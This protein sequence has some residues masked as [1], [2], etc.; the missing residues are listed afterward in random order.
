MRALTVEEI[1]MVDGGIKAALGGITEI[2][3]GL[4]LG[5]IGTALAGAAGVGYATGTWIYN[6]LPTSAQDTIGGTVAMAIENLG[7]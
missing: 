1:E 6:N 7:Y 2:E 3:E 4:T 5:A